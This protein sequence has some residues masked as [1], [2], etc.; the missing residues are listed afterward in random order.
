MNNNEHLTKNVIESYLGIAIIDTV[1]AQLRTVAP[2]GPVF[3]PDEEGMREYLNGVSD[4]YRNVLTL[5]APTLDTF[6]WETGELVVEWLRENEPA[7]IDP[8][9]I[10]EYE[11]DPLASMDVDLVDQIVADI[12]QAFAGVI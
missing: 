12:I 7:L 10:E 3:T 1:D 6:V 9:Q 11:G 8:E 5:I 2:Y 4:T